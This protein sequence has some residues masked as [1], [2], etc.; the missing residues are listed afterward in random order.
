M[1]ILMGALVAVLVAGCLQKEGEDLTAKL[2]APAAD[3]STP[4]RAIKSYWAMR[5]WYINISHADHTQRQSSPA[6]KKKRELED[7]LVS[8]EINKE[9]RTPWRRETFE[10]TIKEVKTETE[11]RAVVLVNIKNNTQL[12]PDE[13]PDS[14]DRKRRD[15]GEMYKYVLEKFGSNW[16][17]A[18]ISSYRD[19]KKD[20]DV[21]RPSKR[22]VPSMT[23]S[24]Q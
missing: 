11:S 23:Y 2:P 15:E 12:A 7:L 1:R 13:V 24:A 14:F 17:V 3:T 21:T 8:E 6:E 18:E 9:S 19:Y 10:R 22:P 4:D 20:W 5:D 16:K